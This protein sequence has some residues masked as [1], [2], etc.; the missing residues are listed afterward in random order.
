MNFINIA[1]SLIRYCFLMR[2]PL[3][4]LTNKIGG[5]IVYI[6]SKIRM[7][8]VLNIT[9]IWYFTIVFTLVLLNMM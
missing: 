2:A 6:L 5:P 4:N 1:M 3:G 7:A 8:L 9:L